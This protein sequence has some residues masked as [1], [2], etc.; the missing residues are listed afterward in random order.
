MEALTEIPEIMK[1]DADSLIRDVVKKDDFARINGKIEI[2]RDLALKLF[3]A[4][5]LSY[6]TEVLPAQI[7][8]DKEVVYMV[9]ARVFLPE[10]RIAEGI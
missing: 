8:S 3:A 9:K 5:R 6:T 4:S 1:I 7:I 10:S 2:E